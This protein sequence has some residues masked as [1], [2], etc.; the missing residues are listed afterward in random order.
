MRKESADIAF[1]AK[2][3]EIIGLMKSLGTTKNI[4]KV[5]VFLSK[6]GETTS[7]TIESS[8]SLKQSEVSIIL[9]GL[10]DKGWVSSRSIRKKVKGR[11]TQVHK[12]RFSLK[13]IVKDLEREKL[14]EMED[15]KKRIARL[16][17]LSK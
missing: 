9:K 13:R 16:K 11:P 8:V 7:R 1:N 5:L 10:R 6:V 17:S 12:L 2:E 4:S 14:G 15:I 3:R